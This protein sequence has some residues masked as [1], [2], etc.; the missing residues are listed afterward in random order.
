MFFL[1]FHTENRTIDHHG[2][3]DHHVSHIH[4]SPYVI[5][6][7]LIVLAIFSVFSGWVF[8][9]S[10]LNSYFGSAVFVKDLSALTH[11][12][13]ELINSNNLFF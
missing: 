12:K 7:P 1:V 6:I 10:I 8:F 2:H 11:I 3:N 4:E 13:H 9:D 5:T